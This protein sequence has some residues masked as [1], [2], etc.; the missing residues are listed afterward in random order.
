[1][2]SE[3]NQT[4]KISILGTRG[5]PAQHG[6]FE[7]FA[8]HFAVYLQQKDW[9][10]TVYCQEKG[11]SSSY[12]DDWSGIHRVHIPVMQDG[13]KGTIV[14]DWKSTLHAV[15]RNNPVLTLGYNTA[16]FCTLYRLRGIKN[17]VN[18]DGVEW[19][20]AK[21]SP[22]ERAWLY[23]NEK[24]GGWLGNHLIADHPEIR[25]HLSQFVSKDKITVIP[26]SAD[27]IETADASLLSQ[28][29]L[30]P[31]KYTIL[32]A[33]PEPENS[34]LEV[35]RAYSKIKRGFP[36]VILGNYNP[37]KS[38][39]QRQVIDAASD[40]IKFVG[41]LYSKPLVQALRF[42]A[43]LNI[44]GHTVGGTNPSLVE[45]LG[46]GTPILAHDN[47][48]NRWVA[49]E[50][51]HFFSSEDSCTAELDS[52]LNNDRELKIMREYNRKQMLTHF[53]WDKV[54]TA[55]E[56]LLLKFQ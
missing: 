21:W 2:I 52:L 33:R 25:I 31:D 29:N 10:V 15:K 36:L 26:Y 32:I 19:R 54:H 24:L 44:H 30:A 11:N 45:A 14:F 5:I 42:Y 3:I 40:E 39:Y 34:I 48:F 18:M 12:E 27:I 49:G 20:R 13:A 16:I 22:L 41:A 9:Q 35:V 53:T 38:D 1:M 28:F 55:Y 47:K 8:E 46:A 6:G 50:V 37:V 7:T 51:A 4:K 17:V 43:R 23:I 56:Q